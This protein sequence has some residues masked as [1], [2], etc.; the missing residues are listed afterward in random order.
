MSGFEGRQMWFV[1]PG[2]D[3]SAL[4]PSTRSACGHPSWDDKKIGALPQA[5]CWILG[6]AVP[7]A[8]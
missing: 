8:S 4:A 5:N 7:L 3:Q 6:W 1:R 2:R